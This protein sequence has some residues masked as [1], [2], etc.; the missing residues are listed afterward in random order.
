MGTV[1]GHGSNK[2]SI[3]PLGRH[4]A[5]L[6]V[7][8]KIRRSSSNYFVVP[9]RGWVSISKGFIKQPG[10]PMLNGESILIN[11]D[12][13][14]IDTVV[15]INKNSVVEL[16]DNMAT[17][18][19]IHAI[20]RVLVPPG[21]NIQ[22]FLETCA[23]SSVSGCYV[24]QSVREAGYQF[25]ACDCS[26]TEEQCNAETKD[27]LFPIWAIDGCANICLCDMG[28]G[29]YQLS[30]EPAET[31]HTCDCSTEACAGGDV[32]CSAKGAAY[33]WTDECVSCQCPS[34]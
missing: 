32:S 4:V 31:Q 16:V 8:T 12:N 34:L 22:E 9:C 7:I 19:V 28:T 18:G 13:Y 23:S 29:C 26:M 21:L 17:N 11:I 14:G 20:N 15:T 10:D 6:F 30:P 27:G 2:R 24:S 25:G 3:R 1:H 5:P 33:F